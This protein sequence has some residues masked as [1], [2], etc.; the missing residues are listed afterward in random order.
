MSHPRPQPALPFRQLPLKRVK[1]PAGIDALASVFCTCGDSSAA[2]RAIEQELTRSCRSAGQPHGSGEW[3]I[4][5][6]LLCNLGLTSH[7]STVRHAWLTDSGL[8]ALKFLRE[9]GP[10]WQ[11]LV[12]IEFRGRQ[13][14]AVPTE[15]CIANLRAGK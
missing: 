2:W 10:G 1:L 15:G 8:E 4:A 6:Y 14:W 9:H 13:V 7:G 11:Q 3:L 12:G 5:A